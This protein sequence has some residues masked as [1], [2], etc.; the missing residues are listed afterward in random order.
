MVDGSEGSK[1]L[2]EHLNL[3]WQEREVIC[4]SDSDFL[5]DNIGISASVTD[6]LVLLSFSS[7]S[8]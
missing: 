6:L 3:D 8:S 1:A 5:L 4:V 2:F 7:I